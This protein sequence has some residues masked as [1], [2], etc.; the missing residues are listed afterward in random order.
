M[1][2]PPVG[3]AAAA[4]PR[5]IGPEL[6]GDLASLGLV[7]LIGF[8]ARLGKTGDLRL[9][10]DGWQATIC[11]QRGRL[12][13]AVLG[14]AAGWTALELLLLRDPSAK[15]A[16]SAGPPGV[17]PNLTAPNRTW[18]GLSEEAED[19]IFSMD[20]ASLAV[21]RAV[22]GRSSVSAIAAKHGWPRTLKAL[23]QLRELDLITFN[24]S[25]AS[26]AQ[27]HQSPL[28]TADSI[29]RE[30]PRP[31]RRKRV[32]V[33]GL[34]SGVAALLALVLIAGR[35]TSSVM[36][37]HGA[38]MEPLLHPGQMLLLNRG[39]YASSD[40][41]GPR[42]GEI[43]VFHRVAPGEDETM[44][45]RVI[46]LPGDFVMVKAGQVFIDGTPLD[47]P[48]VKATDDYSYPLDGQPARV[49]DG[50]YFVLGDNRP[51]SFDSH[52]GWFVPARDVLGQAW[53]LPLAIPSLPVP[54]SASA[55]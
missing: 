42:R 50:Q 36:F 2:P 54:S 14:Q 33:A 11:L 48:Y 18:T 34:L 49:P 22:D 47:E 38:S 26:D 27:P 16:F 32:I 3:P 46:G 10:G 12:I 1:Y 13:A 35:V 4:R 23:V 19:E 41:A 5:R 31:T 30:A 44:V 53:P 40:H 37:V 17:A 21:L 6:S 20:R 7:A 8:L 9:A 39:A 51:V 29:R 43:V 45:K 28:A 24:T 52:L 15:F 25:I 55:V